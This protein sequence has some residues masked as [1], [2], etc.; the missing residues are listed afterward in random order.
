MVYMVIAMGLLIMEIVVWWL[1]HETTHTAMDAMVRIRTKLE[2][3][4][5]Q[6][7]ITRAVALVK[8]RG[9]RLLLWSRSMTLR[10]VIKNFVLRPGE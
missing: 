2:R 1:T 10:D 8:G 3:H 4:V 5:S 7:S 6:D 9:Q